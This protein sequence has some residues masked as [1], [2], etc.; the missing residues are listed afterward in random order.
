MKAVR[1]WLL[2]IRPKTLIASISPVLI[3]TTLALSDGFFNPFLFLVTLLTAM[4]IQISTNLANDYFD[5]LKGA[6][7][8]ERKGPLR[9]MQAGLVSSARMQKAITLVMALTFLMGCALIAR[10]GIAIAC[11]VV[12]SLALAL[13]YTA[14]PYSLAYLGLG[15]LFV[16]LFFGS[17]AVSC[18]HYLQTLS[19]SKEAFLAGIAPGCFSTAIL[20]AN[21]VRDVEEDRKAHKKT[22]VVRFGKTFG[23]I[24]YVCCILLAFIPPLVFCRAHP[25]SLLTL[26]ILLPAVPLLRGMLR[27]K[28]HTPARL[29]HIFVYTGKLLYIF[30]FLFCL[31]WML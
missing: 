17:L 5:F 9:V 30:T 7:N 24:E 19:F 12:V 2:A 6:D 16:L 11:L 27:E 26:L 8:A 21:N 29:N 15:E 23:M 13:L 22:L 14:G 10:G 1:I 3:G 28:E 18:T 20:I 25:F 4:G 31:G